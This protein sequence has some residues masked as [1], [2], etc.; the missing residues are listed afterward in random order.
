MK[1]PCSSC[2][3]AI[4]ETHCPKMV[5]YDPQFLNYY[6][7]PC[8]KC[9]KYEKY[10]LFRESKRKYQKGDQIKTLTDFVSYI[11]FRQSGD[12]GDCYLYIRDKIYHFDWILSL[13]FRCIMKSVYNGNV[14]E[15]IKK[16]DNK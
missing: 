12:D 11:E 4:K 14:Y 3:N 15:A 6:N 8:Y 2:E 9:D 7:S 10:K 5:K 16:E 13:Q 1:K